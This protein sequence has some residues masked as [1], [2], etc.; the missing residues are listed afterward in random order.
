MLTV[1]RPCYK[2][3]GDLWHEDHTP[4]GACVSYHLSIPDNVFGQYTPHHILEALQ[5]YR[6]TLR[7]LLQA[8]F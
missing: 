2:L 4:T 3:N 6:D 8:G 7:A 5:N 1:S